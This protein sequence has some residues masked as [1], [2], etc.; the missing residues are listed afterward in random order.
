MSNVKKNYCYKCKFASKQFKVCNLTHISCQKEECNP[1]EALR[2]VFD[3]CAH[4]ELKDEL[5]EKIIKENVFTCI[6]CACEV[7]AEYSFKTPNTCY[8]CDEA[9]SLDELLV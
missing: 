1:W 3:T 2:V 9:I 5:K 8:L 6:I 7:P 4:F